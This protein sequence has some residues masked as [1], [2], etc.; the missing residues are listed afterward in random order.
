MVSTRPSSY[1]CTSE[2]LKHSKSLSRTR[3]SL[4][5]DYSTNQE[6]HV[7]RFHDSG[8]VGFIW[9]ILGIKRTQLD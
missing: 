6:N 4:R 3:I 8:N 9:V 7:H 2:V 1:G 5:F